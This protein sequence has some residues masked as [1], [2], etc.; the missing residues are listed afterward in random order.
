MPAGVDMPK[1]DKQ[2]SSHSLSGENR[3]VSH[4][5][6]EQRRV[7][8]KHVPG[9]SQ[10]FADIRGRI[11]KQEKTTTSRV[12]AKTVKHLAAGTQTR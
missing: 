8:K 5:S 9:R 12:S 10:V 6:G 4:D 2:A 3:L 1:S 11:A 7:E